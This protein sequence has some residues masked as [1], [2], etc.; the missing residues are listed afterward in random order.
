MGTALG[1][2]NED[3]GVV[4]VKTIGLTIATGFYYD[5]QTCLKNDARDAAAAG[6]R[7][8]DDPQH[9][10]NIL[11]NNFAY[12]KCTLMTHRTTCGKIVNV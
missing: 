11:H 1:S 7:M 5:S 10:E 4:G 9:G 6:N 2:T 8:Y 3:E 12:I